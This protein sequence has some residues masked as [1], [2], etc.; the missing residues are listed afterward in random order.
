MHVM[1]PT[2]SSRSLSLGSNKL[3]RDGAVCTLI[4]TVLLM[5]VENV[6]LV[7]KGKSKKGKV[8]RGKWKGA[9]GIILTPCA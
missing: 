1:N 2:S 9:N 4:V 5:G 7:K 8:E 3:A 6:I